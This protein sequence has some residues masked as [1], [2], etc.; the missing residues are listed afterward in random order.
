M[1]AQDGT[2]FQ[3]GAFNGERH[4]LCSRSC[5]TRASHLAIKRSME[6]EPLSNSEADLGAG[7]GTRHPTAL[8]LVAGPNSILLSCIY[9]AFS[10]GSSGPHTRD[11]LEYAPRM[12]LSR[13]LE[14]VDEEEGR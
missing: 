1:F 3:L 9:P 4:R 2:A 14:V 11:T 12:G 7:G 5:S 6:L 8:L 13:R 10:V